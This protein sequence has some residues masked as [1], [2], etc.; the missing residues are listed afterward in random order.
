M[1]G[2]KLIQMFDLKFGNNEKHETLTFSDTFQAGFTDSVCCS[3]DSPTANCQTSG[4]SSFLFANCSNQSYKA[5][6]VFGKYCS[7]IC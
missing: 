5:L 1:Y 6:R 2:F 7:E 4:L 3:R